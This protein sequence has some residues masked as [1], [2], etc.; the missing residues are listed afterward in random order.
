M[1]RE[2]QPGIWPSETITAWLLEPS[3]PCVRW[4]TL[5]ELL[6]K[7]DDDPEVREAAEA[8][9]RW[10]PI[11]RVLQMAADPA[12]FAWPDGI[13][14]RAAP[15]GRDF[16]R[17]AYAPGRDLARLACVGVPPGRPELSLGAAALKQ[18]LPD[19]RESNCY[20]PQMAAALVRF[21]DPADPDV[22]GLVE[23]VVANEPLADGN[24]PPTDRS[25]ACGVSHSCHS[26]V[27]RALD[28][29]ASVPEPMRTPMMRDFLARGAAYLSDHRLF[30][31]N[32]HRFRPI[33]SEY[34]K[35]HQPWALDWLT[36]ILDLVDIAT[37]VG[38]ADSPSLVPALRLLLDKQGP[39]GRW[40]LEVGYRTDR[41]L[42][43]NLL[44]DV[45]EAGG[46]GKWVTLTALLL[47]R[48]CAGLVQQIQDGVD[49][50]TPPPQPVT[51]FLPYPWGDDPAD[52]ARVRAAWEGL[53]GMSP[54]LDGLVTFAR[55]SGL[56]V[57]WYRGFVMGPADCREWCASEARLIPARTVRAALPVA[58][59]LFLAPR[60]VFTVDDLEERLGV[61][62]RHPYPN[63]VRPGSWVEKA[64]WRL[65]VDRWNARWD[66]VGV[67]IRD[68]DELPVVT[69]VMAEA[70]A[71]AGSSGWSPE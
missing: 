41:P 26:A 31:K 18:L 35:L 53:P 44:H 50:P 49:F 66:T 39:D 21:G 60:G 6:G 16:V 20:P 22:P 45:E 57:G 54:V 7:A 1:P 27:A 59:T 61:E 12:G 8:I 71:A 11:A 3:N 29:V 32:R 33:R 52:R 51:S 67:A 37:R 70:L 2:A 10:P 55:D 19:M 28:C 40:P 23:R 64:L 30:Q 47:L 4:R 46:P 15:P 25:N 36:D 68:A 24:R 9:C 56:E 34:T 69:Q 58:R 62:R 42:V 48:R 43:A 65:R 17:V 14:L 13:R 5:R 63:R 38:L